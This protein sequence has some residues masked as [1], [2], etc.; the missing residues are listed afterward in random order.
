VPAEEKQLHFSEEPIWIQVLFRPLYPAGRRA[1][2]RRG[3]L[4]DVGTVRVQPACQTRGLTPTIR[5][6]H[7]LRLRRSPSTLPTI[8][9]ADQYVGLDNLKPL[10]DWSTRILPEIPS[11]QVP[12]RGRYSGEY[13]KAGSIQ[14]NTF[15]FPFPDNEFTFVLAVS[16]FTHMFLPDVNNYLRKFPAYCARTADFLQRFFFC[17]K[18]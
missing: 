15:R 3:I 12:P 13:N 14:A 10:I 2:L 9:P 6:R 4:R 1:V 11:V 17:A 7:R 16:L 5:P 8:C 18:T